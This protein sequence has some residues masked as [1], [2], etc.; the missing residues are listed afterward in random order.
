MVFI[1]S[2][3]QVR[4]QLINQLGEIIQQKEI[5]NT[6][7]FD[8]TSFPTDVYFIKIE[9]TQKSYKIIKQ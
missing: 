6:G 7:S 3:Q 1:K 2:E 8:L 9:A 4:A 5:M